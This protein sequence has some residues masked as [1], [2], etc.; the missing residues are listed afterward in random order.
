M[1]LTIECTEE[2]ANLIVRSLEIAF[3]PLMNQWMDLAY[4]L[5]DDSYTYDKSN[6]NNDK[7][8]DRHIQN[9]DILEGLLKTAGRINYGHKTTSSATARN[10]SDM[11]SVLRHELYLANNGEKDSWDVR[12]REP[13]QIGEYPLIKC[14]VE[15]EERKNDE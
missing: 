10:I 3:R 2:Q 13:I 12:S 8:F 4:W 11:W 5:A 6:P 14:E 9:R 15:L 7:L 1:K